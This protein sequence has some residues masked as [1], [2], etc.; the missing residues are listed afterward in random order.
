MKFNEFEKLIKMSQADL[1][2]YVNRE[3]KKYYDKENLFFNTAFTMA[4][5]D[6]PIALVAHLDVVYDEDHRELITTYFDPVEEVMF[7]PDGL[8]ADDRAGV[9][10]ILELVRQGLRPHV[11]FT[12]N[13]ESLLTGAKALAQCN[14]LKNLSFVI[15]LDRQG[16]GECVFYQCDNPQFTS[17]IES[18]GFFTAPGSY[19]DISI[20]C[21]VWGIAGVNLSVGYYNE[22]S[23]GEYIIGP[24]W[25][26]TYYKV[27]D[28]LED[29]AEMTKK[30]QYM[31]KKKIT[32]TLG[33]MTYSTR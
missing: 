4:V 16:M 33:G 10:M 12:T 24:D 32:D 27:I 22:H 20:F 11:I 23:Y 1:K 26:Y 7:S 9:L 17:F 13:E 2:K 14:P 21:P 3:L 28:I 25:D 8:G 15:E 18:Y 29:N 6:I 5:G 31:P 19:T 30:W